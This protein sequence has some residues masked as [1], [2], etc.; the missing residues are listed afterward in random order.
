MLIDTHM[1]PTL[2]ICHFRLAGESLLIGHL[3]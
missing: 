2:L 3:D 1:L